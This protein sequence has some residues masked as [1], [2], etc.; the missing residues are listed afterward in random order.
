MAV[1]VA[2]GGVLMD[3]HRTRPTNDKSQ[4]A[5]HLFTPHA[6]RQRGRA[7]APPTKCRQMNQT[8]VCHSSE[9][10]S[11]PILNCLDGFDPSAV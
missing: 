1:F 9:V 8:N 6:I 5:G 4:N 3:W 11:P 2:S 7:T 10:N